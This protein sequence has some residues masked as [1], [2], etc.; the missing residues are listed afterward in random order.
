[1][2]NHP[3]L[4]FNQNVIQQTSL[5]KHLGMFLNSKLNLSE[6][7]NNIFQKTSKTIGLLRKLQVLLPRAPLITI[8]KS[9]VR[10]HLDCGDMTNDQ[11]FDMS[12]QQKWKPFSITQL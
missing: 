10:P 12:F 6:H 5:Q 8:Y 7:L 11:T 1:M 2:I 4:F 3:L 9:P